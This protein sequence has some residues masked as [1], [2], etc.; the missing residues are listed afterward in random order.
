M[1][2][3]QPEPF[4]ITLALYDARAEKKISEDFH[5]DPNAET[6]RSMIPNELLN[7]TD[8]L[9]SVNGA[10]SGEPDLYGVDPKWLAYCDRVSCCSWDVS[11]EIGSFVRPHGFT[12]MVL[13][14]IA[15]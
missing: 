13:L 12:Q 11:N 14:V 6:I 5:F 15:W 1:V 7:A 10:T 9:N 3:F 4:F 2:V 8:M